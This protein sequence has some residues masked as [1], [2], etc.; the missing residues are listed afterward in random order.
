MGQSW[1]AISFAAAFILTAG[2]WRVAVLSSTRFTWYGLAV[3]VSVPLFGT[4]TL[5]VRNVADPQVQPMALIR[6]TD[7]PG[8]S[9][10]GIYVTEASDR[11]Y[12]A[13]I[14]TEGC[15][16]EVTP[17]SGRLQWV[18]KGEVVA[19][20]VGPLQDIDKAGKAAIEM[21]NAL[22]PSIETPNGEQVS[23]SPS[24]AAEPEAPKEDEGKGDGEEEDE[25]ESKEDEGGETEG[26]GGEGGQGKG[27][28]GGGKGEEGQ[29]KEE[30]GGD[31]EEEAGEQGEAKAVTLD[32]RLAG[33]GPAIRPN[34][35]TGLKLVP[36]AAQPG[37][38]VE[39]RMS[40]PNNEND[41]EGFGKAGEGHDLRLNGVRLAVLRVPVQNP[42]QA[43]YVKTVGGR[44]LPID[45]YFK[46]TEEDGPRVESTT[47]FVRLESES[48]H[49]VTD[50]NG[51]ERGNFTVQL[52][53][54]GKLAPLPAKK[55][56][57]EG[58]EEAP[59]S[60]IL[61]NGEEEQ[62]ESVLLRR[63]WS[64]TRIKFRVPDNATGGVVSVACGQ[65]GGEPVLDVVHPP[66]ARIAVRVHPGTERLTFDSSRSTDESEATPKRVW[67]VGGRRLAGKDM[68][69]TE[70][71]PRQAPYEVSLTISDPGG[72]SDR[73]ELRMWRLP[74]SSF[75]GARAKR[76]RAKRLR[77]R[78]RVRDAL[79]EAIGEEGPAN[80]EFDGHAD[81]GTGDVGH[82]LNEAERLRSLLFAPHEAHLEGAGDGT[83]GVEVP[84]RAVQ[85][86]EAP[87]AKPLLNGGA[88]VPVLLRAFGQS[89]PI[90]RHPGPQSVND[91]VEVFLLGPGATVGT[92]KHCRAAR[93][94][95]VYW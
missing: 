24:G 27:E 95:R 18:P 86:P 26:K 16:E 91:R 38:V 83:G 23:P 2:V 54:H 46:V 88:A 11:V 9:I 12:F 78:R 43:E 81:F 84:S 17:D 72:L 14:A 13:S 45:A 76:K 65:L 47:G 49:S 56:G 5:M 29:G 7:G 36:A 44:V 73:A 85:K 70:L 57:D 58:D 89:C 42:S 55:G 67:R 51:K 4:C 21:A 19:M 64:P 52:D 22:T 79:E 61:P 1:L 31:K 60:V 37:D 3:F 40:A 77:Y 48:V 6:T 62:L 50:A 74:S 15:R 39:L 32:R 33:A 82:S 90:V 93:S 66:V 80:I 53:A 28:E 75:D 59:P 30:E 68:V 10:Q 92:G 35:G 41:V 34:F 8:E 87:D 20:S 25:A 94:S 63:A 71:P 69:S